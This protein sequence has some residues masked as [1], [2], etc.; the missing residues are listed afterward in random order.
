MIVRKVSRPRFEEGEPVS[1]PASHSEGKSEAVEASL[2][3]R[4]LDKWMAELLDPDSWGTI[5]DTYGRT[6]RLAVALTDVRGKL[7]GPCHNPQPVWSLARQHAVE[8]GNPVCAFCLSPQPPC[9]AVA[10]ALASGEAVYSQDQ[11]GLAHATIPLFLGHRQVATLMA[12]QCFSQYPQPLALQRVAKH[13]GASQQELWDAAVHQIPVSHATLRRYAELL[14]SLGQ[15]FLRQR[16]AAILERALARSN[17]RYRLMIEGSTGHAHFTVDGAGRVT[18]WNRGAERLLGYREDEIAGQNYSRFF[19]PEDIRDGI[20]ARQIQRLE[21][22]GWIED[23][24]WQV[25]KDDTR[26]LSETVSARLD[27]ADAREYGFLLRDVTGARNLAES[28]LQAQKLES[29]GV[30][31]GGIAHDFN[32]LLTSI[33]GNVSL[34]MMGLPEDDPRC[35]LL[36]LA[37]RAGQKAAALIGQLLA[38]VGKGNFIVTRFDLS[39]LIAE[40]LPLIETSIPKTVLL[41]LHLATGLPWIMADP[42]EIQ[43]IVMNLVIN[44]A[45]AFSPDGG[46]LRVSTGVADDGGVHLEVV[47]TGCGM[48]DATRRRIFDPFFTTKF[49]GRRLGLAAVSGIV[50]RL[51]GRLDVESVPG[52]GSTFRVAFPGVPP[53]P[54]PEPIAIVRSAAEK[55][56]V[57]L[58]VDDDLLVRNLART[59]LERFGYSVLLAENG[60]AAVNV[61]RSHAD[62]ITA[63]LLDLTMP[64]MGGDEAFHM[65]KAIRADIPIIISTGYGETGIREQFAGELGGVIQ[66]PYTVAELG[67]KVGAVLALARAAQPRTGRASGS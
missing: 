40:I 15:A 28:A 54:L 39:A 27:G 46:S 29:I 13:F 50:R 6:M 47:D 11:A 23:E 34:A 10:E 38:Y 16:Y 53:A 59:I 18:S 51:K 36:G 48:D 24:G 65:M 9:N 56:G 63:V 25:R 17:E 32:N 30:L 5:L 60:K 44:G 37:E 3:A 61:F 67:E 4:E 35:S 43:Q 2:S 14:A 19:T 31:A 7:L 45:E 55:G 1:A 12:G 41:D 49:T 66:K 58:V 52:E 57:I 33:S 22:S 20:P 21:Q 42:S 64:V 8:E 62:T 26:F